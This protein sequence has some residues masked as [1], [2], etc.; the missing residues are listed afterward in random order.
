MTTMVGPTR[1]EIAEALTHLAHRA[2]REFP[3]V[4]T[5]DTPTEWDRRHKAIDALLD[6]LERI[7]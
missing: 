6:E 4:G 7:G 2:A 3:V 1:T 5:T